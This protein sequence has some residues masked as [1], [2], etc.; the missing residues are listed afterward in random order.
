MANTNQSMINYIL[1]NNINP[2]QVKLTYYNRVI[3]AKRF[4]SD[5]QKIA[6]YLRAVDVKKGDSII[7]CM[8]NMPEAIVALYA[9]NTV[10]AVA[11]IVHPKIGPEALVRIVKE[12]DT[13]IIFM[14]DRF[15]KNHEKTLKG[16]NIMVIGCSISHYVRGFLRLVW[17]T[18]PRNFHG[19]NVV[20][21][22]KAITFGSNSILS[23]PVSSRN[24]TGD[25]PAV[26]LHSSGT[27][28]EPKT[29]ILSNRALNELS[30]NIYNSVDPVL[31][32]MPDHRMI[33]SLPLFHGFGL[34]VCVHFMMYFGSAH[35]QIA[36]DPF[37]TAK[38]IRQFKGDHI[39]I[40]LVP[41]M[42]RKVINS[43]NFN[44]AHLK[45]LQAMFIGGDK[46]DETLLEKSNEILRRNGSD[47]IVCEGFGL[48]E[49]SSVT[50]INL[51]CKP[52]GTVGKP[53]CNV[54][55]KIM[56]DNKEVPP[57]TEGDL[58]ICTPSVMSGY[59]KSKVENDI[60]ITDENGDVWIK[61]GD[62]AIID[63]EGYLYY[64]GRVKRMIII[65][66]VNIYPQEV[67]AVAVSVP[68]V[69]NA[70]AVRTVT[71]RK[72][73]CLKLLVILNE[74]LTLTM[75]LKQKIENAIRAG[76]L[77]YAVPKEIIQV[78]KLELN[79]IGKTNYRYYEELEEKGENK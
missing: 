60:L 3:H 52:G 32:F 6:K 13:K 44:G 78:D 79:G 36:F 38:I 1:S 10:G 31:N 20:N 72:K 35:L 56:V 42:L 62:R 5:I 15:I 26:Y 70:C 64:R 61:T 39:L 28:G 40:C 4:F 17:F 51:E 49:T 37:Q 43:P 65:G 22:S 14:F 16:L 75:G 68:E 67:E 24:I 7:I 29:V 48:S 73:P 8:P 66:G 27:T 71:N 33:M 69:V 19:L 18:E 30:Q 46:L 47:C 74:G 12:S 50:N 57:N 9:I 34:G 55:E 77:P 63:E 11:N 2:N 76:I 21:Y 23:T 58:Y 41:N 53:I 25:D 54:R 45:K 59:Y